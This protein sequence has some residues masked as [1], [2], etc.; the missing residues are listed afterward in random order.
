M[1]LPNRWDNVSYLLQW[2]VLVERPE[3]VLT[4]GA[5]AVNFSTS[6]HLEV[7]HKKAAF[8]F[9]L[10]SLHFFKICMEFF[11]FILICFITLL[12]ELIQFLH[13]HD[14]SICMT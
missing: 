11:I 9:R 13:K 5:M 1:H 2:L 14:I 6:L 10:Y 3:I 4:D 8:S 12:V 7:L